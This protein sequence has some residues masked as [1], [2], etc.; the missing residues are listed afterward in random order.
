MNTA[1]P[2]TNQN[3]TPPPAGVR[4]ATV[5]IDGQPWV[6]R[7]DNFAQVEHAYQAWKV[8]EYG[9]PLDAQQRNAIHSAL[10]TLLDQAGTGITNVPDVNR[11]F[12]EHAWDTLAQ[13]YGPSG[14]AAGNY[15]PQPADVKHYLEIAAAVA[16]IVAALWLVGRKR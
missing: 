4:Q 5:S 13:F 7:D 16:T 3:L 14:V 12:F 2:T 10:M 8:R 15:T 6:L 1:V 11:N 9:Q